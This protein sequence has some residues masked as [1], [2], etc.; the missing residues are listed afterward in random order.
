MRPRLAGDKAR[1]A[2]TTSAF[3]VGRRP[4]S[5]DRDDRQIGLIAF[6]AHG[7]RYPRGPGFNRGGLLAACR[8][9]RGEREDK[10][11]L[12]HGGETS[13]PE[14]EHGKSPFRYDAAEVPQAGH[15][16][17]DSCEKHFAFFIQ[18]YGFNCNKQVHHGPHIGFARD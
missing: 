6:T 3:V 17:R 12:D 8:E 5:R 14:L 16:L 7:R 15:M 11:G 4:G 10:S 2:F 9:H 13:L 18:L 1:P